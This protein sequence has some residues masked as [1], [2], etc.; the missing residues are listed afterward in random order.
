MTAFLSQPHWDFF[1]QYEMKYYMLCWDSGLLLFLVCHP[2]LKESTFTNSVILYIFKKQSGFSDKVCPLKPNYINVSNFK[3][4]ELGQPS[5][6]LIK[7]I[8]ISMLSWNSYENKHLCHLCL[9]VF[10]NG[11]R[12]EEMVSIPDFNISTLGLT[13][14]RT[15]IRFFSYS[16][17]EKPRF[18]VPTKVWIWLKFGKAKKIHIVVFRWTVSLH[19]NDS[20][21]KA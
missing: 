14:K 1:F 11:T 12:Q 5:A 8:E 15:C 21:R 6:K 18:S 13:S 3:G 20:N 7:L 4:W 17:R 9:G 16:L 2:S 10:P 19:L